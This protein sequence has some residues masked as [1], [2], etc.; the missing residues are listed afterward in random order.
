MEDA[1]VLV[2]HPHLISA[3]IKTAILISGTKKPTL[4]VSPRLRWS[5]NFLIVSYLKKDLIRIDRCTPCNR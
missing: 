3:F 1:A 2:S 5:K 4:W